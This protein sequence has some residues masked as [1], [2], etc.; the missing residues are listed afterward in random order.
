MN[1]AGIVQHRHD[2]HHRRRCHDDED[3]VAPDSARLAAADAPACP[4]ARSCVRVQQRLQHHHHHH[5][6]DDHHDSNHDFGDA[7]D[8][9]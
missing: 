9:Q 4:R 3:G 8:E 5:H 6:V 2:H 1:I 7:H